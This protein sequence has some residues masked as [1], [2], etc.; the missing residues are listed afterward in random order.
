MI[1]FKLI[2]Y[3]PMKDNIDLEGKVNNWLKDHPNIISLQ[4]VS[5]IR[6]TENFISPT[7]ILIFY[8]EKENNNG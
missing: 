4:N 1:K 5:V 6:N 3:N 8:E 2:V 7:N